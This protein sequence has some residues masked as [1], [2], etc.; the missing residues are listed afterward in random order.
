MDVR[1]SKGFTL[2]ELLVVIAVIAILAVQLL[3]VSAMT[4][5][6]AR[7]LQCVSNIKEI[8][9]AFSV[10][11]GEHGDKY[12]TAVRTTNGGAEEN[13]V[14]ADYA[15]LVIGGANMVYGVANVFRVMTNELKTFKVLYCPA[16]TTRTA[17]TNWAGFD[18]TGLSYFVE[19]D[20]AAQ[21]PKM[22]LIGDRNIGN[23]I[24]GQVGAA[25][26][27]NWGILPADSMFTPNSNKAFASSA[28]I[29]A[30]AKVLP[31]AWT[32]SDLHQDSGNLGMADGSANQTSLVGLTKPIQDT[33]TN[34]IPG[35]TKI[36]F[37]M[38]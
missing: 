6:N 14:N 8:G 35:Y 31:W 7:R 28:Q 17:A 38:P 12:P 22:I 4:G 32:D 20:A 27:P 37:N 33:S 19:G 9:L 24:N 21:Y 25:A 23:V 34:S 30:T 29:G 11:G 3:Q 1:P 36:I 26:L 16:D 13:I 18:N 5:K 15:T 2:V 10:W